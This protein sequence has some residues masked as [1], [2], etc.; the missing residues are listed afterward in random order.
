MPTL[1]ANVPLHAMLPSPQARGATSPFTL[2]GERL[3]LDFVNTD[4]VRR[5]ARI[6]L[7]RDFESLVRFLEAGAILDGERATGMT[8]GLTY[9]GDDVPYCGND[10][11]AW[12]KWHRHHGGGP[13]SAPRILIKGI[14]V[15]D[16]LHLELDF[17][18]VGPQRVDAELG[19]LAPVTRGVR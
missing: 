19:A 12:L 13:I 6:D 4:D 1:H 7:L 17:G 14:P 10:I 3:W 8:V 9:D 5:G 11:Q 2:I 15:P 18:Q 16:V